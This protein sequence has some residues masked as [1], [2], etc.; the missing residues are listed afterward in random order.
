MARQP[1]NRLG[2]RKVARFVADSHPRVF[3]DKRRNTAKFSTHR[4]LRLNMVHF[5]VEFIDH[6]LHTRGAGIFGNFQRILNLFCHRFLRSREYYSSSADGLILTGH[7]LRNPHTMYHDI[8][9]HTEIEV[10]VLVLAT[11]AA[12]SKRISSRSRE[13]DDETKM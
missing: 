9:M 10:V 11:A 8:R 3:A 1:H 12:G 7:D 6:Q 13:T 4:T 2:N 5:F